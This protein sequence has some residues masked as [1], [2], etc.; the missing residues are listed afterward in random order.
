MTTDLQIPI[1]AAK[2]LDLTHTVSGNKLLV[3]RNTLGDLAFH[4]PDD[5]IAGFREVDVRA[6]LLLLQQFRAEVDRLKRTG[7]QPKSLTQD[8]LS[9]L[10]DR[11]VQAAT[12]LGF[13]FVRH[14]WGVR[15]FDS[16]HLN[17]V[18]F[19]VDSKAPTGQVEAS[20]DLD[21]LTRSIDRLKRFRVELER[22]NVEQVPEGWCQ[23]GP[24]FISTLNF[25]G[26]PR[27][28]ARISPAARSHV[29]ALLDWMD[30]QDTK[31]A[32]P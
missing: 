7:L 3:Y 29:R 13:A 22:L 10:F 30:R 27:I 21:F 4:Y 5:Y 32:K 1:Q 14:L 25:E 20:T 28:E 26:A 24:F 9:S 2:N 8:E 23:K 16:V 15:V 6:N 19:E 31:K 11:C 18:A 12:N 17:Q